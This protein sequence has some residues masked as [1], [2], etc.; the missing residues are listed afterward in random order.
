MKAKVKPNAEYD[1]DNEIEDKKGKR[2]TKE[3][4]IPIT[5]RIPEDWPI[6]EFT[7]LWEAFREMRIK[8]KSKMTEYAEV[9]NV[10]DLVKLS[11]SEWDEAVKVLETAIRR[12]W[13]GFYPPDK[14][15]IPPKSKLPPGHYEPRKFEEF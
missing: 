9:L 3:K 8:S 1:I 5:D 4:P 14:N 13:K 6:P 10:K 11:G 7:E 15:V 2:I 12:G